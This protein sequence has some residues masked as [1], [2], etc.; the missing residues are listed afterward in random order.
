MY[1]RFV[2]GHVPRSGISISVFQCKAIRD[3]LTVTHKAVP[4]LCFESGR[5]VETQES[6]L[7]EGGMHIYE[8][9]G[10]LGHLDGIKAVL[11]GT[12][13]QYRRLAAR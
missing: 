5:S 1:R 6:W 13:S 3:L 10:E 11:Q 4:H 12:E 7:S 8:G 9:G 2:L